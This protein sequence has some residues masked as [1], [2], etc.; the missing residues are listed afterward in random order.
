MTRKAWIAIGGLSA[1]SAALAIALVVALASDDVVNES[2]VDGQP[3]LSVG[4]TD[5]FAECMR[6]QGVEPPQVGAAPGV[7]PEGAQDALEACAGELPQGAGPGQ[8]GPSQ[9]APP[10]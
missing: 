3:A 1:L 8:F 10:E 4:G 2:G 9:I 6:E 7:M 5:E